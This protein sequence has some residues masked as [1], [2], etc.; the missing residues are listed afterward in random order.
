MFVQ[1][2]HFRRRGEMAKKKRR[3][4]KKRTRRLAHERLEQRRLLAGDVAASWQNVA[5]P[6]DVNNDENVTPLDALLIAN[7]LIERGSHGLDPSGDANR[8]RLSVDV[9]GDGALTREDFESVAAHLNDPARRVHGARDDAMDSAIEVSTGRHGTM[10][11]FA[12]DFVFAIDVSAGPS[13]DFQLMRDGRQ[14]RTQATGASLDVGWAPFEADPSGGATEANGR[15]HWPR[16]LAA[17]RIQLAAERLFGQDFAHANARVLRSLP[18]IDELAR[19]MATGSPTSVR[20]GRVAPSSVAVAAPGR[21]G[22]LVVSASG[23]E[24]EDPN[25]PPEAVMDYYDVTRNSTLEEVEFGV[26]W[27]DTDP[28]GDDLLATLEE[29]PSHAA[30]F[31]FNSDGSFSYTPDPL[32]PPFRRHKFVARLGIILTDSTCRG[33]APAQ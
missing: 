29:D 11:R 4:R 32:E 23:A 5:N 14:Y 3:S 21:S 27:N 17:D 6:L 28:D 25:S 19:A 1:A 26:L 9:D 7:Q 8:P 15:P 20:A 22:G 18:V 2:L 31:T 33:A 16:D 13:R 12:D 30:S 10:V 24:G